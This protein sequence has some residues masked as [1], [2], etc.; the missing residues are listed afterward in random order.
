MSK[1]FLNIIPEDIRT[2]IT[3]PA[4][5]DCDNVQYNCLQGTQAYKIYRSDCKDGWSAYDSERTTGEKSIHGKIISACCGDNCS[6]V[7]KTMPVGD[8]ATFA[9]IEL[10]INRQDHISKENIT[11]KIHEFIVLNGT[12]FIIMDAYFETVKRSLLRHIDDEI[13]NRFKA[14]PVDISKYATE[15]LIQLYDSTFAECIALLGKL[16]NLNIKHGDAHLDNFMYTTDSVETREMKIIDFGESVNVT[17]QEDLK[18]DYGQLIESFK[19]LHNHT[20]SFANFKVAKGII[21]YD[22]KSVAIY[23]KES[24]IRWA[25]ISRDIATHVDKWADDKYKLYMPSVSSSSTSSSSITSGSLSKT[26]S[27]SSAMS[28]ETIRDFLNK[29]RPIMHIYISKLECFKLRLN[30]DIIASSSDTKTVITEQQIDDLIDIVYKTIRFEETS[31]CKGV[32]QDKKRCKKSSHYYFCDI[33]RKISCDPE[34]KF[35]THKETLEEFKK[36]IKSTNQELKSFNA[37]FEEII[38]DIRLAQQNIHKILP[39]KS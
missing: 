2:T 11:A 9:L 5:I 15:Y 12:A 16:H 1:I 14:G 32:T 6:Y 33:H 8:H 37:N 19:I 22:E 38:P 17:R 28:S 31:R 30:E 13:M 10:E 4:V 3:V 25:R 39:K 34:A 36:I 29:S 21:K 35:L 26:S 20:D 7:A 18:A 23:D 24:M 27:A